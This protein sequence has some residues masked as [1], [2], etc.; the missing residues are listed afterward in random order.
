MKKYILVL[1]CNILLLINRYTGNISTKCHSESRSD[2][3]DLTEAFHQKVSSLPVSIASDSRYFQPSC[4]CFSVTKYSSLQ[5]PVKA[6]YI[7]I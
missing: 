5:R 4:I 3:R 1:L 6:V 7:Y 2:N